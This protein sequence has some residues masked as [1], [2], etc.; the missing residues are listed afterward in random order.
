MFE[1]YTEG[2]RRVLFFARYEASQ[3]GSISID[4]EH[5]LLGLLREGKGITG[6]L[7]E[8]ARLSLDDLRREIESRVRFH[9]NTPVS[10]EIP[11]TDAAKRAL[12]SAATE[13]DRLLHNYIGTEHLLL[14]L[15][16]DPASGA[17]Q[18][19]AAHGL[20][21]AAVRNDIVMLL[22]EHPH[23]DA[24]ADG[25]RTPTANVSADGIHVSLISAEAPPGVITRFGT[26]FFIASGVT[27]RALL[28]RLLDMDERR[29]D[30]PPA[31]AGP[32]RYECTVRLRRG[33]RPP[34]TAQQ[35]LERL[36]RHLGASLTREQRP[37]DAYVLTAPHGPTRAMRLTV[38]GGG[39]RGFSFGSVEFSTG[40]GGATTQEPAPAHAGTMHSLG[41]LSISRATMADLAR[42]LEELLEY[43]VVDETGLAG[44]FDLEVRGQYESVDAFLAAFQDQLG[45]AVAR[46]PVNVEMVIIRR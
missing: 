7:F 12:T 2:A 28:A 27:L 4:T 19:L 26:D 1:R 45:L 30:L 14:G 31:L 34:L 11:F 15:L 20:R 9:E 25:T 24:D 17:G 21:L 23:A 38:D 46:R 35:V 16:S 10:K 39:G 29:I 32:Q 6:R 22:N 18:L 40:I 41:P 36:L 8:R 44:R 13:A 43:P 42:S 37:L 5:V 33:E 3:L